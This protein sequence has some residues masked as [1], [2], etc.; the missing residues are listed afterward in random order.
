MRGLLLGLLCL[1]GVCASGADAVCQSTTDSNLLKAMEHVVWSH[2][3]YSTEVPGDGNNSRGAVYISLKHGLDALW[4]CYVWNVEL[5]LPQCVIPGTTGQGIAYMG[6]W[7]G[8]ERSGLSA[9]AE[10][11]FLVEWD[12]SLVKSNERVPSNSWSVKPH[13]HPG[14]REKDYM[15]NLVVTLSATNNPDAVLTVG[16]KS[17]WLFPVEFRRWER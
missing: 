5:E 17:E 6:S 13:C 11:R 14:L 10:V 15:G 2:R 9:G 1:G 3:V 8:V 4:T 16:G 7:L 12:D